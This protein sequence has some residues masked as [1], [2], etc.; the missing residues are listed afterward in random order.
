YAVGDFDVCAALAEVNFA[1]WDTTY[2][3]WM[4]V[5]GGLSGH[6]NTIELIDT[7]LLLGG[8]FLYQNDTVGIIRWTASNSYELFTKNITNIDVTDIAKYK[9][10]VYAIGNR[11]NTTDTSFVF[12][13]RG[14]EW[15]PPT[16]FYTRFVAYSIKG[17]LQNEVLEFNTLCV[18]ND[19]LMVGGDFVLRGVMRNYQHSFD[20]HGN[21]YAPFVDFLVDS[22]INKMVVFKN[23]LIFGGKF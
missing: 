17:A 3:I 6:I 22:A 7:A 1:K 19:T 21:G 13:L 5:D 14:D 18:D 20:L 15:K 12:A 2:N 10:T 8:R 11:L 4:Q 16:T 9:D 23:E